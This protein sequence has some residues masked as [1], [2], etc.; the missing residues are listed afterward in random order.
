MKK[1]SVVV[2]TDPDEITIRDVAIACLILGLDVP[3]PHL[4]GREDR[5]PWIPD[6]AELEMQNEG[7]P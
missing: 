2:H 6:D 1:G 4:V 7:K 5:K 3:V